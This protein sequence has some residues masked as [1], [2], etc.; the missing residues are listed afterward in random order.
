MR[1]SIALVQKALQCAG[2][3]YRPKRKVRTLTR[4]PPGRLD[5]TSPREL[6]DALFKGL[7]ALGL[8]DRTELSHGLAVDCDDE[9]PSLAH[10]AN[11]RGQ[12][13]L[14]VVDGIMFSHTE[15]WLVW[16]D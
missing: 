5:D 3:S 6:R 9:R 13:R 1:R 8:L 12:L 10:L 2:L 15:I 11:K 7:R 16:S 4:G 14:G